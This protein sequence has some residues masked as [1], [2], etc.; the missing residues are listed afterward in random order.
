MTRD[1]DKTKAELTQ[2]LKNLCQRVAELE[3]AEAKHKRTE[4]ALRESEQK[5]RVLFS[6]GDD[7]IFVHRLTTDG[8]VGKFIEVNDV[9][10]QRLGYSREELLALSGADIMLPENMKGAKAIVAKLLADKHVLFETVH[11]AKDGTRIPVEISTRLFELNG[12]PTVFPIARDITERKRMAEE[13]RQ[14]QENL[15]QR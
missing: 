15:E 4:E 9:A 10:C 7:A 2:E 11:L 1:K 5:Y 8:E 14:S 6:S 3:A 12:Q 13:L